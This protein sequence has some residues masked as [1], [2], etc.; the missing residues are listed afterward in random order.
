MMN[1]TIIDEV[2]T[3]GVLKSMHERVFNHLGFKKTNCIRFTWD[4][5][6]EV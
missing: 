3:C 6:L 5:F 1:K 4:K 2:C